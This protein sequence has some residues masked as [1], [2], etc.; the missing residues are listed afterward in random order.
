LSLFF[1]N[2]LK[3]FNLAKIILKTDEEEMKKICLKEKQNILK[4][5]LYNYKKN[6]LNVL[7]LGVIGNGKN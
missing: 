5:N 4:S 2:Y 6:Y 3:D 7:L 1:K